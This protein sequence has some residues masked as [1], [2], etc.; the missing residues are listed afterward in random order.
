MIEQSETQPARRDRYGVPSI[1]IAVVAGLLYAYILWGA[2]GNLIQLP[3][4]LGT[5]TP[6]WLLIVDVAVPAVVYL[7]AILLGLRQR[8]VT[9]A[10]LFVLGATVLG[11]C[12]VGSI[13][14]VQTH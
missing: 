14:F 12:T 10:V 8:F 3:K 9:R 11:C 4:E 5:L 2:I 1:V 13:A 7:A 6:W